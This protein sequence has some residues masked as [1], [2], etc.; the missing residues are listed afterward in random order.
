[1]QLWLQKSEL[2]E[3][4]ARRQRILA[5]LPYV[6]RGQSPWAI[7]CCFP[8]YIS[9][10]QMGLEPELHCEMSALRAAA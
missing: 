6:C 5:V 10:E 7:I 1:M 9:R 4:E 3:T 8:R 2:K